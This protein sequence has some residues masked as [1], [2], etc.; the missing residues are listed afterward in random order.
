MSELKVTGKIKQFL[1]VQSGTAKSSGNE[2]QKQSFIVVNN[3]GYEGKE[4]IYCFEVFGQDKVENLTKFQKEG[5]EVSVSF[6]IS[7]NEWKG[8][9]FTGLQAWRIEK[10]ETQDLP[11]VGQFQPSANV[12]NSE[13]DD[14]PF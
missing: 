6:N 1:E 13:P 10:A 5:D 4:Q 2:W 14:L 8:K 12:T 7:T 9:Y 3:E 11:P